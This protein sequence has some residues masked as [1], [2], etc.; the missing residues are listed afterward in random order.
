LFDPR[1]SF[2][3]PGFNVYDSAQ[4][5]GG[6]KRSGMGRE[7]GEEALANYLEHKSVTTKLF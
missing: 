6:F 4:P 1:H 2:I 3:L 5:F 7:L